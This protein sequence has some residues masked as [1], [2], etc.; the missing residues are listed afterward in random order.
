MATA[1]PTTAEQIVLG[2]R[3]KNWREK[4]GLTFDDAAKVLGMHHTA[5]RRLEAA[6]VTLKPPYAKELLNLYRVPAGERA[7]FLDELA[8]AN[9]PGWWRAFKD[10]LLPPEGLFLSLEG[11]AGLIRSYESQSVPD[12][13]QTEDY[14]RALTRATHSEAPDEEIERRVALAMERQRR[15]LRGDGPATTLWTVVDE[16]ALRRAVGGPD[17]MRHQIEHLVEASMLPHV[18]LQVMPHK[19]GLYPGMSESFHLFR[20][21]A[22]DLP[23]IVYRTSLN[24]GEY[25]FHETNAYLASLDRLG[26]AAAALRH[27]ADFLRH[28]NATVWA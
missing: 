2:R 18:K 1:T 3:L 14:A 16:T 12:L 27:T 19:V 25:L 11:Y 6:L 28:I 15:H 9:Q 23:D 24:G 20:F 8:V 7:A 17:V 13:L 10:V 21:T 5:V 22:P 26:V 4:A